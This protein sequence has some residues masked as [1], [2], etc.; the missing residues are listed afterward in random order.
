MNYICVLRLSAL[1]DCCHA[2][3]VI[4]RLRIE[5]PD[6]TILW[7]IGKTEHQLFKE[8]KG[9]EFIVI[10]K[11]RLARS[12][13][14]AFLEL[15]KYKFD[16]LFNL[17]ASMSANLISLCV[18]AVRKIGYDQAR[19]RDKQRW[20]CNESISPSSNK[21]VADGMM[22][23]LRHLNINVAAPSWAPLTLVPEEDET[24][25]RIDTARL[26][27]VISPCSS[28]RYGE[29]YNRSWSAENFVKIIRFLSEEKRIQVIISGGRSQV[30][31]KYSA[32]F[33][34]SDFTKNVLNL[35]GQTSIR[36]MASLIKSADFVLSPDS[37]PAHI[38]TVMGKPV[39]GL[40]AMSNPHRSGPYHSLDSVVNRYPDALLKYNQKSVEAVKWG[41]KVKVSQAMELVDFSDVVDKLAQLI[42]ILEKKIKD[43]S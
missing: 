29:K 43:S 33:D 7:I 15:R 13:V 12:L 39:V 21:H 18:R 9:V 6:T 20:F 35:I 38:A 17:H 32:I 1:G 42:N 19:A 37:G 16:L 31:E 26:T 41:Q 27:C 5:F 8:L 10:D 24:K 28:Q 25:H 23:F 22:D 36:E 30:E 3:S 34:S 11:S 40:Y 2:L 4:Q 14:S